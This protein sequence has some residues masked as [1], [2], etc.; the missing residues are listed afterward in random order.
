MLGLKQH[1]QHTSH[2]VQ[3]ICA[4]C[5]KMFLLLSDLAKHYQVMNHFPPRLFLCSRCDQEFPTREA[6]LVHIA[7]SGHLYDENLLC[8]D[9]DITFTS[10]SSLKMHLMK[11][12]SMTTREVKAYQSKAQPHSGLKKAAI[13]PPTA[14]G[15]KAKLK[16]GPKSKHV[17]PAPANSLMDQ[18]LFTCLTCGRTATA[19]NAMAMHTVDAQHLK[20]Y[21]SQSTAKGKKR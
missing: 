13:I 11:D 21:K 6:Q 8:R 15:P 19:E 3:F 10:A 20:G 17:H 9:C 14:K 12:H 7:T 16:N 5:D 4:H 18:D 2:P 1:S